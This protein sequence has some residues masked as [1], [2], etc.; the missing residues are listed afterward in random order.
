MNET[1]EDYTYLLQGIPVDTA[2]HWTKWDWGVVQP[3]TSYA[4]ARLEEYR[5]CVILAYRLY[6]KIGLA[7]LFQSLL[8][9]PQQSSIL[10]AGGGTG[11]KAIPLALN[12]YQNITLMDHAP[13]WL[14][15]ACERAES[16]GVSK[17]IQF[18]HGNILNMDEIPSDSFD[19]VFA[20]G[21]VISYCGKPAKAISE[22][23]R[24]LKPGGKLFA[25]GIHNTLGT[26]HLLA[27]MGQLQD[28]ETLVNRGK[29]FTNTAILAPGHLRKMAADNG[30]T[31]INVWSEFMFLPDDSIRLGPDTPGWEKLIL[32]LEL[33][34]YKDMRF[35]GAGHLM[36][37]AYK[38]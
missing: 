28:L 27:S 9:V 4:H 33:R 10:D 34:H 21:G 38:V 19:F 8:D 6:N 30:L 26:M 5:D 14:R 3:V 15:F 11:R 20:M 12:G 29:E 18:Q 16:T 1:E 23:V 25:D 35:L 17:Q 36:L 13:D 37:S 2:G 31:D 22:L 32:K 24:V 7:H